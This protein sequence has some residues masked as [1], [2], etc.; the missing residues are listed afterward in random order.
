MC[1]FCCKIFLLDFGAYSLQ[2]GIASYIVLDIES[3]F[4]NL[5]CSCSMSQNLTT[6]RGGERKTFVLQFAISPSPPLNSG[7]G[8]VRAGWK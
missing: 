8:E 7:E 2:K 5:L 4:R 1:G 3:T 6:L